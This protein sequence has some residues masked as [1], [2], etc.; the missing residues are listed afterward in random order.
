MISDERSDD[1]VYDRIFAPGDSLGLDHVDSE[2]VQESAVLTA[3][4]WEASQ[5]H[6][7]PIAT[8]QATQKS[9]V[10]SGS[11]EDLPNMRD[12]LQ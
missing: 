10:T 12:L 8:L 5:S 4:F 7:A 9:R 2:D 6:I 1:V 11:S 3:D